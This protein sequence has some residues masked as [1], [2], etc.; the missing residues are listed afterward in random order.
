VFDDAEVPYQA[1]DALPLAAEPF[2][3]ALDLVFSFALAEATRGTLVDLLSSPLWLFEADGVAPGPDDISAADTVLREAKYLGG[4]GPLA[5]LAVSLGPEPGGAARE[6][7]Q[8]ARRTRAL[9]AVAAARAAADQLQPVI[10]GATASEQVTALLTFVHTHERMPSRDEPWYTRHARARAAV[11][12]A[13]ESLR[14]AHAR[15]DDEP[16]PL[17]HLIGTIRR[18]I[19]GQ[20]FSPRTGTS[21]VVL[22]D[23]PAAAYADMDE[24]RLVGLVERDWPERSPRS[25]FYPSSLLQ[26]LGWPAEGERSSAA[27]ARFHDLLLLAKRR[28]S[29]SA[30]TL[31]DDSIVAPSP[32]LEELELSGLPIERTLPPEAARML[33]HEALA[34]DPVEPSAVKGAAAE[35]LEVRMSRSPDAGDMSRGAAGARPPAV[36]AVSHLERYLE[37]PFKYFAAHVLR[38]PEE[39]PDES[40]LTPQERGQFLHEVFEAFFGEWQAAGRGAITTANVAE[41]T[42]LFERVAEARL[43][44]LPEADRALERTLVLGSAAASGLAERAFAFEIEQGSGVI[45]RLLEHALEGE[46]VFRSGGAERRLQLRAKAD[47]IDLLDDGTLRIVDYKL[48]RAPKPARALQLPV[49]GICAEQSLDGRHGR[50]WTLSRA[51]YVAFREKQPFTALGASSSLPEAVEEGQARLLATVDRIERGEFPV[52]PDEPFLCTRCGYAGVC[53]KDYVGDE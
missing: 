22:L 9:R 44:R 31:E 15:H 13:L 10:A 18:W 14:E 29:V 28:V 21:G 8:A 7:R 41:A 46:F 34:E 49:Y 27:R 42:A 36:Y 20:T 17:A 5:A 6:T 39:R 33:I 43:A 35:W 48:S 53:R 26:Q 32:F 12:A 25:I 37:C 23:A 40:G 19:E 1:V 16:L 38:L 4:W 30:F 50:S 52:D 51:G 3:A 11:L 2:A 45:E 47:R 24:V